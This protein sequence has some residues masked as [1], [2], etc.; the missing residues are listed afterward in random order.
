MT[1]FIVA[2]YLLY[3]LGFAAIA[4]GVP[5]YRSYIPILIFFTF[6]WVFNYRRCTFSYIECVLRNVKKENGVLYN[7]LENS[8]DLRYSRHILI[9]Y[10]LSAIILV[11]YF[12][13]KGNRFEDII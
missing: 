7:L 1:I 9:Y 13:W 3:S 6:K 12:Y 11:Y 2:F 5:L 8:V 4:C 10:I